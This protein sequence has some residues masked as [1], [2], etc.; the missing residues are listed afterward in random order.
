[1]SPVGDNFRKKI[2]TFPGI[3]NCTTIDW[4]H[5]WPSDALYST[6]SYSI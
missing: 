1:M 2:R 3:V 4:F 6:A 5:P